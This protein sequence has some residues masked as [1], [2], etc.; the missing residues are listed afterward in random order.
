MATSIS[1]NETRSR[2]DDT[3]DPVSA[4]RLSVELTEKIDD[5]AALHEISRSEAIGRLVE[6][7][8][9]AKR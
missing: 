4:V 1:V 7:G 9:K 8:L 6:L 2:R 5:Y 3:V